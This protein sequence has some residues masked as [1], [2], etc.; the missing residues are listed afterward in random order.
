MSIRIK[1]SLI[2]W[3]ANKKLAINKRE[4]FNHLCNQISSI[5]EFQTH[6][7][8]ELQFIIDEDSV[9]FDII[10][11]NINEDEPEL[12]NIALESQEQAIFDSLGENIKHVHTYNDLVCAGEREK[13]LL[14]DKEHKH[15]PSRMG[16][17]LSKLN[18]DSVELS[19]NSEAP[20][21]IEKT[22]AIKVEQ[23]ETKIETVERCL[24]NKPEL[25][26]T[27]SATF[28]SRNKEHKITAELVIPED[29]KSEALALAIDGLYVDITFEC[30][31]G[32][33]GRKMSGYLTEIK[34]STFQQI[35][36]EESVE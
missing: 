6:P 23:T 20:L 16:S 24:I 29:L 11:K 31:T 7:G 32:I 1:V 15:I 25:I 17:S 5:L 21:F 35:S 22:A 12:D 26:K 27:C 9:V 2:T 28:V 10:N 19:L 4:K 30:E 33:R 14:F 3:L 18:T 36:I 34:K 8:T 13:A